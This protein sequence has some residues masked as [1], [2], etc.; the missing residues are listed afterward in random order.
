VKV[1]EILHDHLD[2][3]SMGRISSTSHD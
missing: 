3:W 1:N 2:R